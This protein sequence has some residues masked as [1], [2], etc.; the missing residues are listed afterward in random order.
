MEGETVQGIFNQKGVEKFDVFFTRDNPYGSADERKNR[1]WNVQYNY[2]K[3]RKIVL[4]KYDKVWFCESDTIPPVTALSDMLAVDA[5]VVSGVYVQRH[6]TDDPNLFRFDERP[7]MNLMTWG[8]LSASRGKVVRING[9][10]TGCLLLDRSVLE[11][12]S[13]DLGVARYPDFA[14]M[15]YCMANGIAQMGHL[16]VLCGHK[17]PTGEI[18]W[19]QDYMGDV[20]G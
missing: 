11:G 7:I 10:C 15:E 1:M 20:N 19:P 17:K 12:F 5:P 3:M 16:G 8:E 18:L 6:G 13:F 2:E 9:G 4:E 14:L